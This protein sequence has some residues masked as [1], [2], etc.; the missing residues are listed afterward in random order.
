MFPSLTTALLSSLTDVLQNPVSVT[1]F[2]FIT[3]LVIALIFAMFFPSWRD[4]LI[5]LKLLEEDEAPSSLLLWIIFIIVIVKLIQGFVIQPF[6]VD[7]GSMLPTYHTK[8]F[9]IVDKFSYLVGTPHRGD[10]MIFKLY[11]NKNNPYEG[12]HLIKRVIGL[13]GERVVVQNGVTTIYNKEN[14]EGFTV[15]EPFVEFKEYKK[16]V[17]VTLD[18]HHYFVMGDNRAQSYDSRD[19]GTLSEDNIKGQVLLRV[20]PFKD[21][22][23]EPGQ[24]MYTK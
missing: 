21:A 22:S 4:Q 12:K 5:A 24:Y 15:D 7:G 1:I 8:D 14:P 3:L 18:E 19:W 9:L 2:G 16:N 6:I 13:P 20:Y 10:V 23:Y 17:D 11:E